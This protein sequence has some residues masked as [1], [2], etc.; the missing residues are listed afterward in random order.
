[1]KKRG[2]ICDNRGRNWTN[3]GTNQRTPRTAGQPPEAIKR[4]RWI[5]FHNMQREYDPACTLILD[6]V[7]FKTISE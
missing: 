1:M 6:F 4:Q 2:H 7:A 5:L 3:K